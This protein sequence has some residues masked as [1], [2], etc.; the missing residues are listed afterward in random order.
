MERIVDLLPLA[1]FVRIVDGSGI[2]R[3]Q[4]LTVRQH[5]FLLVLIAAG[6]DL[7]NNVGRIHRIIIPGVLACCLKRI[8]LDL[9]R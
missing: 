1:I 3:Q 8:F 5:V 2:D 7:G 4:M 9:D 6:Y